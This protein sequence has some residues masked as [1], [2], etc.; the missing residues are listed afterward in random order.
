MT[1][2]GLSSLFRKNPYDKRAS[3]TGAMMERSG[4][5][6]PFLAAAM[7][8]DLGR[9]EKW[10]EDKDNVIM[11]LY[12]G[13]VQK[14][15]ADKVLTNIIKISQFDPKAATAILKKEASENPNLAPFADIEFSAPTTKENWATVKSG[16]GQQYQVY[17]PGLAEIQKSPN[18]KT[19]FD[20]YVIS[21]GV[22]GDIEGAKPTATTREWRLN[23][24]QRKGRGERELSWEEYKAWLSD[25]DDPSGIKKQMRTES[26]ADAVAASSPK[27]RPNESIERWLDRVGTNI[28]SGEK[29]PK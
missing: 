5:A 12:R 21:I 9:A 7:G 14:E 28:F 2:A 29:R 19:I 8:Q 16:D 6:K 20:K 4:M 26:D 3:V 18:D 1:T 15:H 11:S 23:N 13:N 24:Q 22:S 25:L 27:K 17:L 10:D